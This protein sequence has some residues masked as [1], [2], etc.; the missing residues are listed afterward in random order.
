VQ[1]VAGRIHTIEPVS[2][3]DTPALDCRGL[4]LSPGLLDD[5]GD[6]EHA[7]LVTP[8]D[9]ARLV[10]G[11]TCEILGASGLGPAPVR[12]TDQ[13]EARA[14]LAVRAGYPELP[15]RW[16]YPF[17]YL[18]AVS[19]ARPS[20]NAL[21]LLP[22]GAVRRYITGTSKH[23]PD[24]AE[25]AAINLLLE[26][27]LRD[28]SCGVSLSLSEPP[29]A[30]ASPEEWRNL[31]QICAARGAPIWVKTTQ[32]SDEENFAAL[33]DIAQAEGAPLRARGALAASASPGEIARELSLSDR[34]ELL[35][36][37]WADLVAHDTSGALV[38][39]WVNGEPVI[40]HGQATHA[41]PGQVLRAAWSLRG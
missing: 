30:W 21:Y 8:E 26:G 29:S 4:V 2:A 27:G 35:P 9:P 15:W 25:Q 19:R 3:R 12:P 1:I 16:R 5:Q 23:P 7:I 14:Q 33:R 13:R 31:A 17:E 41:R 39:A 22:Y 38:H 10:G 32:A 36:G 34:G 24:E 40:S 18:D 6:A 11:V 20:R 37:Y 28:G